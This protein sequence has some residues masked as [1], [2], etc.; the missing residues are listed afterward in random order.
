MASQCLQSIISKFRNCYIPMAHEVFYEIDI[1]GEHFTS[2]TVKSKE[3]H[4]PVVT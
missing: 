4:S 2:L 1:F 3:N